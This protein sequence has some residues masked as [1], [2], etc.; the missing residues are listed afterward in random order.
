VERG[1]YF[2]PIVTLD[3]QGEVY[4]LAGTAFSPARGVLL[5]CRHVIER[6]ERVAVQN[7]ITDE[8]TEVEA[9]RYDPDGRIDLALIECPFEQHPPTLPVVPTGVVRPGTNVWTYGYYQRSYSPYVI[10]GAFYG[11]RVASVHHASQTE[12]G[13]SEI[14]LPFPIVEGTSGAPLLVEPGQAAGPATTPGFTGVCY[15]SRQQRVVAQEVADVQEG[16]VSRSETLYRV[17]EFGLAFH[18]QAVGGFLARVGVN[19]LTQAQ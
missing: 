18:I 5:T 16:E 12:R 3:D 6:N 19:E 14:L 13:S 9:V 8:V 17:V 11:G 7:L 15:G 4:R 1:D 10:D 2:F